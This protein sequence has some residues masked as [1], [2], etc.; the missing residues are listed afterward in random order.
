[1]TGTRLLLWT[2]V[3]V[4]ATGAFFGLSFAAFA[5]G[6]GDWV[7]FFQSPARVGAVV[8]SLVLSGAVAFSGFGGMNPGKKEDRRNRWIFVPFVALSLVLAVLPA[9]LDGRNLLDRR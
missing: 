3:G 9:Y 8:V 7:A 6:R 2:A 4:L 5:V 1:M